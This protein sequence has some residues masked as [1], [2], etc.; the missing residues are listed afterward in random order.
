MVYCA[1]CRINITNSYV[2]KHKLTQKHIHNLTIIN[3]RY[4]TIF[5]NL[6]HR[7]LTLH[8]I[9]KF[10]KSISTKEQSTQTDIIIQYPP[11]TNRNITYNIPIQFN[12][13]QNFYDGDYENDN[14]FPR[15]KHYL[16]KC[17]RR[18]KRRKIKVN[19]IYLT[20][21]YKYLILL[22]YK[23]KYKLDSIH[24]FKNNL[25]SSQKDKQNMINQNIIQQY[26]TPSPITIYPYKKSSFKDLWENEKKKIHNNN[27]NNTK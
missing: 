11:D 16:E 21:I 6:I 17:K 25:I 27:N 4:S 1:I 13:Q 12:I 5:N 20:M 18:R 14:N 3:N 2:K 7:K 24:N 22:Y 26:S 19:K 23:Y 10:K 15:K 9:R 8:F